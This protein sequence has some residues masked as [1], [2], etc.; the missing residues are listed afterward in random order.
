M[1]KKLFFFDEVIIGSGFSAYLCSKINKKAKIISP[2]YMLNFQDYSRRKNLEK[3]L[4]FKQILNKK[5]K[6]LGI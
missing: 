3:N 2:N 1:N 5:M 6:S 4:F